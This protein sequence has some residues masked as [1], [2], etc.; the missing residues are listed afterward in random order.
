MRITP[1][2]RGSLGQEA[3][4]SQAAAEVQVYQSGISFV[5]RVPLGYGGCVLFVLPASPYPEHI[6]HTKE[7]SL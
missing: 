7:E 5:I 4:F 3:G 1:C 2:E 6:V